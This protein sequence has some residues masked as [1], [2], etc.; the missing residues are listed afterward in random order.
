MAKEIN[1]RF[2]ESRTPFTSIRVQQ[3]FAEPSLTKQAFKSECDIQNILAQYTKTG[4]L[5]HTAPVPPQFAD[6][7]SLTLLEAMTVVQDAETIFEG[8]P[9]KLRQR[10][11]SPA[12]LLGFL[13][14]PSNLDEAVFLGLIE[15]D[16]PSPPEI[17]SMA[18]LEPPETSPE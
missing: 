10:F 4:I 13:E 16:P 7:P 8:L 6:L 15:A 1:S 11:R 18:I 5:P 17:A 3:S 14:N 12:E 2:R 9:S